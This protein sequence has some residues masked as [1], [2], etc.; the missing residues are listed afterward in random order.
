MSFNLPTSNTRRC[1]SFSFFLVCF[2]ATPSCAKGSLLTS[3]GELVVPGIESRLAACKACLAHYTIALASE[4]VFR[5]PSCNIF[6]PMC[7]KGI[8]GKHIEQN[9]QHLLVCTRLFKLVELCA[10][11]NLTFIL[12]F[13]RIKVCWNVTSTL[14]MAQIF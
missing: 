10:L 14:N 7:L 5:D 6:N 12:I 3:F 2:G 8:N 1:S 4:A 13:R 9:S 11:G